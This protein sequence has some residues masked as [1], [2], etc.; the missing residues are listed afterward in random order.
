MAQNRRPYSFG[1][2]GHSSLAC[3]WRAAGAAE[4]ARATGKTATAGFADI[5]KAFENIRHHRLVLNAGRFGF[6]PTLMRTL[7]SLYSMPRCIF[8]GKVATD[9]VTASR[10]VVPGC[11]FADLCMMMMVIPTLDAV[12]LRWPRLLVGSVVDDVQVISTGTAEEA[13]ADVTDAL[14]FIVDSLESADLPVSREIQKLV[15]M[16]SS[17]SSRALLGSGRFARQL[18]KHTRNLGVDFCLGARSTVIQQTRLSAARRRAGKLRTVRKAGVSIA[19]VAQIANAGVKALAV[20]GGSVVGF[21]DTAIDKLRRSVHAALCPRFG[22][23]SKTGDLAFTIPKPGSPVDPGVVCLIAPIVAW[24]SATW[25]WTAPDCAGAESPP[26]AA[27]RPTSV[28]SRRTALA[29]GGARH[30]PIRS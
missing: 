16:A 23:R 15:V 28:V 27:Y 12:S 26:D 5:V 4:Y 21:S 3:A 6:N 2:A 22:A 14:A 17:R 8:E 25:P 11:S 19:K 30:A 9:V 18:R 24:A 10:S 1:T 20:Y 29:R 7:V 13:T